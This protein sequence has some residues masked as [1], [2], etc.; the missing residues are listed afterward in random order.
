M[1][2]G[3]PCVTRNN[4]DTMFSR[5]TAATPLVKARSASISEN[6]VCLLP[7]AGTVSFCDSGLNA[8]FSSCSVCVRLM[9]L[10]APSRKRTCRVPPSAFFMA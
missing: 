5:F 8:A 1:L 7:S 4:G 2:A 10:T 6:S 3:S 9:P